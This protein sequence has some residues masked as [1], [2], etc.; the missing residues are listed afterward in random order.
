MKRVLGSLYH[1]VAHRLTGRQL[2]RGRDRGW[3]YPPLED[4]MADAG[5]QE[6]ETYFYRLQNTVVQYIVTRTIMDLC[7][8]EKWRPGPRVSM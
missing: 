1:R 3:F 5:L 8:A 4:A 2:W 6:V 7:M